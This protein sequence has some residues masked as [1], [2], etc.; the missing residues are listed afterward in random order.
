[1]SDF[2]RLDPVFMHEDPDDESHRLGH[3]DPVDESH[4]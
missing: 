2:H 3:E 4:A 1:M